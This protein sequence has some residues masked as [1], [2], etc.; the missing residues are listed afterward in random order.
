MVALADQSDVEARLRRDLTGDEIEWLPGVLDEASALVFAYC[1]D[2]VFDPVPDRVRIVTSRV[3]A[4]A[5]SARTD[6]AAAVTNAAHVF[7]Q[8]V[9]LNAE[10]ANGGVWLTKADRLALQRWALAGKAFSIDISGR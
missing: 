4:R 7:S 1:G 9:T 2:R 6:S 3:A 5:L 8:T 10:A